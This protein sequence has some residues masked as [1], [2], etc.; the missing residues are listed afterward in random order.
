MRFPFTTVLKY[1]LAPVLLLFLAVGLS[2]MPVEIYATSPRAVGMDFALHSGPV[3]QTTITPTASLAFLPLVVRPPLPNAPPAAH[4]SVK[5]TAISSSQISVTWQDYAFNETGFVLYEGSNRVADLGANVT[6]HTVSGFMPASY[7]CFNVYAFNDYG[8]SDWSGWGCA[9]TFSQTLVCTER[10]TNGGFEANTGW[11]LPVTEYPAIYSTAVVHGGV[12]SLRAGIVQASDNRV[13]YS[14]AR[15]SVSIPAGV[16]TATLEFWLYLVSDVATDYAIP[17]APLSG[18][19]WTDFVLAPADDVQYVLVLDANDQ[20]L[21]ALFWE[22]Q[23]DHAWTYYRYDITT[24]RGHSLKVQ[25]GAYN[26][27]QNG[28][29]AMYVDDVALST[30]ALS[31]K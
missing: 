3:P 5:A 2:I 12:Q 24:Y 4:G 20:V 1:M 9:S 13:S 23:N 10:I 19:S 28:V 22:R 30:C 18:A 15:Q 16:Q 7:H 31:T 25:F 17:A 26:N 27:G 29:T 21:E 11:V 6:N 8:R 14:S